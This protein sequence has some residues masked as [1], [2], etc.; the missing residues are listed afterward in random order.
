MIETGKG[1]QG[2]RLI[3]IIVAYMDS[4]AATRI[5]QKLFTRPARNCLRLQC[6]RRL[7]PLNAQLQAQDQR[8]TYIPRHKQDDASG[9]STWQQRI[10]AFP[11]DMSKQL[12]EY[13]RV[14][15]QDLRHRTQRPRRVK[16]LTREF[17]DGRRECGSSCGRRLT[18]R[19]QPVQSQLRLLHQTCHNLQCRKTVR[20]PFYQRRLRIQ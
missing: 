18:V 10:D 11:K 7:A 9:G 14:T 8:R 13:P 4:P 15:A 12:R 19:R 5:F 6:A 20:L 17:M 16:M 2:R 3:D 1:R